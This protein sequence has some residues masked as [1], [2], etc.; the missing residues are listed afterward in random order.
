MVFVEA[1]P[2]PSPAHSLP[3]GAEGTAA[4]Q[5]DKDAAGAQDDAA[6]SMAP[7][8]PSPLRQPT[9]TILAPELPSN[10][11]IT[12]PAHFPIDAAHDI[13]PPS[14]IEAVAASS[15]ALPRGSPALLLSPR[16]ALLNPMEGAAAQDLIAAETATTTDSRPASS[17][18]ALQPSGGPG[19]IAASV[20]NASGFASPL[21]PGSTPPLNNPPNTLPAAAPIAALNPTL[22]Q[23]PKV[24]QAVQAATVDLGAGPDGVP[25]LLTW[26]ADE[27]TMLNGE[28]GMQTGTPEKVFV[29]GTFAKGW[30][31]KIE[32]RRK[33]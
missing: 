11:T 33:E 14:G 18:G 19:T 17:S 13:I 16:A 30:N 15:A 3:S 6:G 25:T 8:L 2:S 31:A 4:G 28:K 32:L 27:E 9:E 10:V 1:V 29:T 26:K 12:V 24:Q 23:D 21:L 5:P 22:A 7:P 20:G